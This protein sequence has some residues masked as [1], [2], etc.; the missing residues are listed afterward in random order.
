ME[1]CTVFCFSF[2]YKPFTSITFNILNTSCLLNLNSPVAGR[3]IPLLKI[4]LTRSMLLFFTYVC[5]MAKILQIAVTW[6]V[7]MFLRVKTQSC[8]LPLNWTFM[9]ALFH[10]FCHLQHTFYTSW[11]YTFFLSSP[12]ATVLSNMCI[13]DSADCLSGWL[14]TVPLSLTVLRFS[15]ACS[16]IAHLCW[17]ISCMVLVVLNSALRFLDVCSCSP[18]SLVS[19]IDFCIIDGGYRPHFSLSFQTCRRLSFFLWNMGSSVL[20]SLASPSKSDESPLLVCMVL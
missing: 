2:T 19:S 3:L 17:L 8:E 4:L 10:L 14:Q 12:A 20:I 16:G 13:L 7:V 5:M 1:C 11:S 18:V 15:A 6:C 9:S